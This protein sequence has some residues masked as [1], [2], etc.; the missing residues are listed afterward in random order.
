MTV[1]PPLAPPPTAHC[2]GE[3][4]NNIIYCEGKMEIFIFKPKYEMNNIPT[5]I[6]LLNF[7]INYLL[8]HLLPQV[9]H[10]LLGEH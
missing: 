8:T 2:G 10:S 3:N 7:R 4:I 5:K 9:V 1:D 6:V